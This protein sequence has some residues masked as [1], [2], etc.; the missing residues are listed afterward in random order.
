MEACAQAMKVPRS[1]TIVLRRTFPELE[2]AII[3]KFRRYIPWREMGARFNESK[4]IVA[5]PN[6]S[7]TRFGYCQNDADVYQ[8]QGDEF[9]FIGIDELTMFTLKQWQFLTSRNRCPVP[10]SF[11][12]MAG[13]SNPGNRGH[14]W[15]KS[16]FIDNRPAPGMERPQEYDPNDYAFIRAT[17]ED[18]SIYANDASY[19]KS[20]DS[21]PPQLYR[22]FRLGDW[23]I[24]AGQYFSNFDLARHTAR[25]Q[26]VKLEYWWPRWISG[27]WGYKH[28]SAFYWHAKDGNRVITYR[29][30]YGA[31]IGESE[32]GRRIVQLSNQ[33][34]D[35][36]GQPI[37]IRSVFGSPDAFSQRDS[38]HTVASQISA[39]LRRGSLPAMAPADNDRV[40]GARLMYEL[41]DSD[42]WLILTSCPR[43]IECI[44]T[45]IYD[46]DN[47]EDVLKVDHTEGAI[48]DDPFDGARYGLKSYQRGVP[49]PQEVKDAAELARI[50]DPTSRMIRA[51][52]L[53]LREQNYNQPFKPKIAPR[54]MIQ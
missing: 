10:G 23:N 51:Y 15:V 19:R 52:Q 30:L 16:M 42:S 28:P 3:D 22:A 8:Y 7:T 4:H 33:D 36:N 43:L 41:L 47:L 18:N 44:P 53:K 9:L 49:I 32:L 38:R 34:R 11:P 39:E 26:D 25:P 20:L 27:D 37:R 21:L 31:G 14:V 2:G 35:L 54:W 17:L 50:S 48:G 46:E 1:D 6:G 12:N 24:H 45:L 5:W 13:T 40:G 29:E